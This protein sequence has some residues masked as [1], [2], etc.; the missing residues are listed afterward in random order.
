MGGGVPHTREIQ[1][2]RVGF[3]I[4]ALS[5]P[6]FAVTQ[7]EMSSKSQSRV[8]CQKMDIHAC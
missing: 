5:R 6:Q 2:K 3:D 4:P 1:M 8:G 7:L